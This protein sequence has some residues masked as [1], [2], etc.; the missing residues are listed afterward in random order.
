MKREII[1]GASI[2]LGLGLAAMPD[3]AEARRHL[4]KY[5]LTDR[6]V[7]LEKKVD[8]AFA[9]NQLTLK[10]SDDLKGRLKW[11]K[12]EEQKMKDKNGG[13]LSYKDKTT[14]ERSLNGISE[15]LQKKMLDKRVQ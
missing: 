7:S 6:Q 1:I 10:E 13:K 8:G 11:V 9:A 4:A 15:K 5:S 12:D 14:L 3:S 2:L